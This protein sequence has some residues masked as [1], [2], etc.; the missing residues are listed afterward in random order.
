MP[1]GCGVTTLA[2]NVPHVAILS[3]VRARTLNVTNTSTGWSSDLELTPG[4][5]LEV[6]DPGFTLSLGYAPRLTVPFDVEASS[7]RC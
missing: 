2:G 4:I 5:A 1:T 7:W 6:V 3:Q